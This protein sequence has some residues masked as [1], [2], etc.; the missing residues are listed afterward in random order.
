MNNYS[1]S[2]VDLCDD[3]ST[4]SG[5]DNNDCK[6]PKRNAHTEYAENT[7]NTK[8]IDSTKGGKS[9]QRSSSTVEKK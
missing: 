4:L 6:R 2:V 9:K 8:T 1:K 5:A 7:E 3:I